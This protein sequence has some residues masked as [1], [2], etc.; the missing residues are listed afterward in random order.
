MLAPALIEPITRA[1]YAMRDTRTPLVVA[2]LAI[3]VNIAGSSI[4]APRLGHSGLALSIS[5][6][7]TLRMLAL[8]VILSRR[9]SGL[10]D[11]LFPSLVRMVP[12]VAIMAIVA[13]GIE[14]AL[15]PIT[16]PANGRSV[17]SYMLFVISL[18]GAGMVFL[19]V[20]Y[21]FRIPELFQFVQAVQRRLGRRR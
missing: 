10:G 5:I 12:A 21:L 2:L 9:T 16:D 13:L 6:T 1:F 8:L 7:S 3:I 15:R 11:R 4:L 17:W 14:T 18:A 20:A 19:V